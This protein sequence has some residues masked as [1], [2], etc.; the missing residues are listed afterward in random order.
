MV[1]CESF[2]ISLAVAYRWTVSPSR[3]EKASFNNE[4]TWFAR[5]VDIS[6]AAD[7]YS[8][9]DNAWTASGKVHHN[10]ESKSSTDILF[11]NVD[12]AGDV[13]IV[14]VTIVIAKEY[15]QSM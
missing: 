8:G 14:A 4:P 15:S 2:A 9:V 11:S 7:P 1:G 5:S 12:C 3:D 10:D 13:W 6:G